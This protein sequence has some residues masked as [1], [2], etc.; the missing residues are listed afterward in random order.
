[1]TRCGFVSLVGAPNAGKSTLLNTILGQKVTI[2]SPKVQ[3]TRRRIFGIHLQN[4]SQIVFVDTPGMFNPST[5]LE[6]AMV[7]AAESSIFDCDIVCVLADV[8]KSL[9]APQKILDKLHNADFPVVLLLNKV[10]KVEKEKLLAIAAELS[11]NYTFIAKIFMI[12]ALKNNGV[13][14]LVEYLVNTIPEGGWMFPDDQITD[15]SDQALAAEITREKLFWCLQQEIP[16]GLHVEHET[17]DDSKKSGL[18]LHQRIVIDRENHKGIVLGK[19][20][21]MLKRIGEMA[22]KEI[23]KV[24]GRKVHLFLYVV[25]KEDWKEKREYYSS[26][27]LEFK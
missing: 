18:K 5:R 20:G 4:D 16:Y 17:W 25:V 23:S 11:Q 14:L 13:D 22:R 7:G 2:V 1:M 9:T 6:K 24:L 21:A 19:N 27:G 12:S 3:T 26:Q 8:T 15:L 10:D